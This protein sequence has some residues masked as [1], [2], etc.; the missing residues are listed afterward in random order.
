MGNSQKQIEFKNS[1]NKSVDNLPNSVT[2][3]K[4]GHDFNQFVDHLPKNLLI[5]KF[6]HNFN[7]PVE[8]LPNMVTHIE[9]GACF[10]QPLK[11]LPKSVKTIYFNHDKS[12]NICTYNNFSIYIKKIIY[13]FITSH[14]S[15]NYSF[16]LTYIS[17]RKTTK[18]KKLP[19]GCVFITI[20]AHQCRG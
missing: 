10:K 17:L 9:F 13:K 3:I 4:F 16:S 5:I 18:Y 1:F 19:Y 12:E 20:K 6:G 2:Y 14:K 7:H 15:L 8:K 11:T